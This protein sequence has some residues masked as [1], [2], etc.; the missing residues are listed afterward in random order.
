MNF[1]KNKLSNGEFGLAKTFWLF[2]YIPMML[3]TFISLSIT[4][5][6]IA[7]ILRVLTV[8]LIV[9]VLMGISNIAKKYEGK[10]VWIVL[11]Q[12][13]M[14]INLIITVLSFSQG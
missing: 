9:M 5:A 11:A 1:L 2:G 8:V 4:N 13:S 14:G 12:I 6:G 3:L 7:T 10:K